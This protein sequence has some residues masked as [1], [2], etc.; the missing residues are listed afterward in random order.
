M[1][2]NNKV[3]LAVLA[4]ALTLT[5]IQSMAQSHGDHS[6]RGRGEFRVCEPYKSDVIGLSN[7]LANF[8]DEVIAP[9][10]RELSV[11]QSKIDQRLRAERKLESVVN[12]IGS[13]ISSSERRLQSIPS[14]IIGNTNLAAAKR[15]EIISLRND[16]VGYEAELR[17]AGFIRKRVLKGKIKRA[18]K[19]ISEAEK[20]ISESIQSSASMEE[21]SRTIPARIISLRDRLTQADSNLAAHRQLLPTLDSMRDEERSIRNRLDSQEDI[22]NDLNQKLTRAER[23]F[24]KCQKIDGDAQVYSHLSVMADRLRKANC[25]FEAVRSRLPFDISKAEKRALVEANDFVCAPAT[26]TVNINQ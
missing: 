22:R 9:L 12:S 5:S 10:S 23:R 6:D 21:E 15:S 17:D 8:Q 18:N 26:P 19:N 24:G 2:K 4:T 1:A 16:I 3:A 11:S 14:L 13:D 7:N 20:A 25:E